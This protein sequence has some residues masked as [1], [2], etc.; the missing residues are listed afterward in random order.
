[1]I[2]K[3]MFVTMVKVKNSTA[4]RVEPMDCSN[5]TPLFMKPMKAKNSERKSEH[6]RGLVTIRYS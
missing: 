1:M 4:N 5:R 6:I 3:R 2:K